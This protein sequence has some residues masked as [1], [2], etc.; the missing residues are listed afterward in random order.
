MTAIK[1]DFWVFAF[2]GFPRGKKGGPWGLALHAD[3]QTV[4]DFMFRT[5]VLD[6]PSLVAEADR[7]DGVEDVA[8]V[9][10]GVK[11]VSDKVR[12]IIE[13]AGPGDCQFI[14]VDVRYKDRSLGLTYW[15]LHVLN[16]VDCAD[17][18]KS[19]Y[20]L[21]GDG[22]TPLYWRVSIIAD[23]VPPHVST[24]RILHGM[25][26]AVIRDSL[27]RALRRAKVT[28]ALYYRP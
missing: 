10:D 12:R 2:G 28:G 1:S 5:G 4:T 23:R 22:T 8:Y 19:D 20:N 25:S 21:R 18:A 14:P 24:F 15:A 16:D 7:P 6:V 26:S 27:R 13:E 9:Y 3:A 11:V 17:H